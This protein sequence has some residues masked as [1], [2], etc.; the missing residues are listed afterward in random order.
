MIVWHCE[1]IV[2]MTTQQVLHLRVTQTGG[3]RPMRAWKEDG[4]PLPNIENV[5][6]M[7][8]SD[9]D[10]P[11]WA[12]DVIQHLEGLPTPAPNAPKIKFKA[13]LQGR[14]A[15]MAVEKDDGQTG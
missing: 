8:R 6:F 7:I 12:A 13:G 5:S 15:R 14:L 9:D 1:A 2:D 3:A 10:D 4:T 11:L